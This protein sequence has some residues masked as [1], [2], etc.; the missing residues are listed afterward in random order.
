MF[1]FYNPAKSQM[2]TNENMRC[3]SD[4]PPPKSVPG[5]CL[6]SVGSYAITALIELLTR[7]ALFEI[8]SLIFVS[9]DSG[10][11]FQKC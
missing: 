11:I 7:S 10:G 5:R 3:A 9:C 2:I 4:A 1:V 6:M 8:R